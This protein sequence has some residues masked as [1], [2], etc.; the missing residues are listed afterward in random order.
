MMRQRGKPH[1]ERGVSVRAS[2]CEDGQM[3]GLVRVWAGGDAFEGELL[4]GRL[5]AEGIAVL[6]KGEAEGPYRVGPLYLWVQEEEAAR[7]RAVIDAVASGAF[8]LT[9][10]DVLGDAP[11]DTEP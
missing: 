11:T 8:A 7:A 3:G 5:Q 10:D 9:D 2:V 4:K 6:A 1:G